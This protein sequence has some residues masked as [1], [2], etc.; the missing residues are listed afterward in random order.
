MMIHDG[1]LKGVI[2]TANR[3]E[4]YLK[5][6]TGDISW[7]DASNLLQQLPPTWQSAEWKANRKAV[8][9]K[10]CEKCGSLDGPFVIQHP[11]HPPSINELIWTIAARGGETIPPHAEFRQMLKD[12]EYADRFAAISQERREC[13]PKCKS[14]AVR[15]SVRAQ[16]WTCNGT[17]QNGLR[18]CNHSFVEP[19]YTMELSPSSKKM[20]ARLNKEIFQ[21]YEK[22]QSSNWKKISRK[23][24]KE[25]VFE[26]LRWAGWYLSLQDTQTYC[27]KCAF[28]EDKLVGL[29]GGPYY[30]TFC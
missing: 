4:I 19:S 15:W 2:L 21:K 1:P 29:I 10:H 14:V 22:A 24:G 8:L 18:R 5:L 17:R 12:G 28:K 25:A 20:V 13:C 23:F 27:K 11:Y 7:Q 3:A 6:F 9:K 16:A 30:E 26:S